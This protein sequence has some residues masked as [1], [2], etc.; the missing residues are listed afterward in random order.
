MSDGTAL[1]NGVDFITVST[2]DY[3][4]AAEFYGETLGLPFGK[5]WGDMPAGEFE[6]GNLTIAVMQSDATTSRRPRPSSSRAASSSRGRRSTQASA[7][8]RSSRTLTATRWRST[9]A[10]PRRTSGQA[11]EPRGTGHALKKALPRP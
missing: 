2:K 9:T 4:K 8:R 10:T 11:P 1:L 3:D 5:R 7:T 6:A